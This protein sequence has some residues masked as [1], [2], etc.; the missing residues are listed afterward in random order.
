M[1]QNVI[2]L[3]GNKGS[4]KT[5]L[6]RAIV[7]HV[8]QKNGIIDSYKISQN[9][10]LLVPSE[11]ESGEPTMKF[12]DLFQ[13]SA[14]WHKYASSNIW[15]F[16]KNYSIAEKLKEVC[17]EWYN[18][19]YE[20]LFGSQEEKNKETTIRW[21]DI[22]FTL[23]PRTIN[24][25]KNDNKLNHFLTGRE[26][27]EEFSRIIRGI[28]DL[29]LLRGCLNTIVREGYPLSI[30]DDGR[31]E[32]EIQ[33]LKNHHDKLEF[34]K[35]R[36]YRHPH[37]SKADTEQAHLIPKKE[38]SYHCYNHDMTIEEKNED[39]INYLEKNNLI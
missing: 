2:I 21:S 29:A 16:V 20:Y 27:M 13:K 19:D 31:R 6:M 9:G 23:P 24:T 5:S 10:G 28:N 17:L 7:G 25:L 14:D 18:V 32:T 1:R 12:L 36:L 38:F 4:G 35:I 26:F 33:E 15:P 30:I 37:R 8:L 34:T 22:S 11:S 39:V 3:F